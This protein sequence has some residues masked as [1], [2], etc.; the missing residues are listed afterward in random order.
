MRHLFPLIGNQVKDICDRRKYT[1]FS[2]CN[3]VFAVYNQKEKGAY[4]MKCKLCYYPGVI[5]PISFGR[6]S[7]NGSYN[8]NYWTKQ[9]QKDKKV[10]M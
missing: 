9:D 6:V 3:E 4:N 7:N 5:T 1:W 8:M 2:F 10:S